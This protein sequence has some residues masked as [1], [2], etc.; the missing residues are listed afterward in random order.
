MKYCFGCGIVTAGQPLYC[1]HCACTFDIKLCPRRHVNPRTA[2]VCSQCGSRDLSRPQP[3]VPWWAPIL[4][5]FLSVIPGAFLTLA[6]LAVG[7]SGIIAILQNPQMIVA[8]ALLAIPFGIL[9]WM[10]SEIPA[11]FRTKIYHLLRH[12]RNREHGGG[13]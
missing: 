8:L 11:W 13:E 1:S 5:W 4:Q 3:R 6:T 12:R 7:L 2:E 9:W 10:W